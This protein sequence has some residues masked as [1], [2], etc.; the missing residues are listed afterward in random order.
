MLLDHG[1]HDLQTSQLPH[2]HGDQFKLAPMRSGSSNR[3]QHAPKPS[4]YDIST[5]PRCD[6]TTLLLRLKCR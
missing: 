6:M 4:N 1:F 2:A 3:R 5:L